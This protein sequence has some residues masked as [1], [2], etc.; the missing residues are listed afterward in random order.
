MVREIG[1]TPSQIACPPCRSAPNCHPV[2]EPCPMP[3]EQKS[4]AGLAAPLPRAAHGASAPISQSAQTDN[5]WRTPMRSHFHVWMLA[6][7][8]VLLLTPAIAAAQQTAPGAGPGPGG[9][10]PPGITPPPG[11]TPGSGLGP[12]AGAG[13]AV[14]QGPGALPAAGE[15]EGG[16]ISAWLLLGLAG[17][18]AAGG[19]LALRRSS[20]R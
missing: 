2:C 18:L 1:P 7:V 13:P 9:G 20:T 3:L 17:V 12:G 10:P 4:G 8:A 16:D 6:L 11:V 14:R 19:G 5:I 15:A